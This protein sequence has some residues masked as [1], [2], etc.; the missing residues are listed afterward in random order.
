MWLI[1]L[2]IDLPHIS[3]LE[4]TTKYRHCGVFS[5]EDGNNPIRIG[6]D[7]FYFFWKSVTLFTI[8]YDLDY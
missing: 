8:L 2:F 6:S 4:R 5:K 3:V 7:S 1:I